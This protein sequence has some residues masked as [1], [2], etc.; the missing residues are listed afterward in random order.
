MVMSLVYQRYDPDFYPDVWKPCKRQ[1]QKWDMS[2]TC[3]YRYLPTFEQFSGI[4]KKYWQDLE[5][6]RGCGTVNGKTV[7][8]HLGLMSFENLTSPPTC[9]S[10]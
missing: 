7:N 3:I 4:F 8:G 1:P 9:A 6:D 10:I 2:Y 5:D